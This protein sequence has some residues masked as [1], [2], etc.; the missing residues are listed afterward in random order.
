[1]KK[2]LIIH[3]WGLGDWMMF[4]PVLRGLLA[5]APEAEIDV[6]L[7][8]A[9]LQGL[10][11]MYPQTKVR[12]RLSRKLNFLNL[13]NLNLIRQMRSQK[14]DYLIFTGGMT[15]WKCDLLSIFFRAREKVA[16]LSGSFQHSLSLTLVDQFNQEQSQYKNNLK[17]LKLLNLPEDDR[18]YLPRAKRDP[19][20]P[21]SVL[22]HPGGDRGNPYKRW[23][24]ENYLALARELRLRG[25]QVGIILGPEEKDLSSL[26][27]E[28]L[29]VKLHQNLSFSELVVV[30]GQYQT[31][32]CNDS[33]LSHLAAGLGLVI[34]DLFGPT[35]AKLYLPPG[36]QH[37]AV[38]RPQALSCQPCY[39]KNP[40]S[41]GCSAMDCM[42]G[43][44]VEQVLDVVAD[45]Q[46]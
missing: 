31:L 30:L 19:P 2:I 1:M 17:I 40:K 32:V 14:Y 13:N 21:F 45:I 33:G 44:T 18:V 43:I 46:K 23:P 25:S 42:K 27:P 5:Q 15:S 34:C 16:L 39:N 37:R 8:Q 28:N 36:T 4:S 29:G 20:T 22:I 10:V 24:L 11:E 6:L 7:T 9:S 26:I 35:D 41:F 3:T 12:G 38:M